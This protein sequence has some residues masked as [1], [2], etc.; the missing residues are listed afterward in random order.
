MKLDDKSELS[1]RV[2]N[3]QSVDDT[4]PNQGDKWFHSTYKYNFM[5][6]TKQW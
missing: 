5:I 3:R 1:S 6:G 2:K 4:I